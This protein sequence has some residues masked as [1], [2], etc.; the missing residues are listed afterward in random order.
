MAKRKY[1]AMKLHSGPKVKFTGIPY[2][3]DVNLPDGC[4]GVMFVFDTKKSARKFWGKNVPLQELE[5]ANK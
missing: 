2:S 1:L 5:E 4:S 3:I